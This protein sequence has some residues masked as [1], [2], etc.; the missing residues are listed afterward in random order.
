MTP[1]FWISLM[2]AYCLLLTIEQRQ[3]FM[4]LRILGTALLSLL[5]LGY[6]S[7]AHAYRSF[8]DRLMNFKFVYGKQWNDF[9][10]RSSSYSSTR[11]SGYSSYYGSSSRPSYSGISSYVTDGR[12]H[13]T[14]EGN[15]LAMEMNYKI[16]AFQ[17]KLFNNG[18]NGLYF[19]LRLG[20]YWTPLENYSYDATADGVVDSSDN[21]NP[22]IAV[23]LSYETY[24][25]DKMI[26]STGVQFGGAVGAGYFYNYGV[27]T[28]LSYNHVGLE[29]KIHRTAIDVMACASTYYSSGCGN[30]ENYDNYFGIGLIIQ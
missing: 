15:Y 7:Q 4:Q 16:Y 12:T 10:H 21:F 5:M 27:S 24:P 19:G 22:E 18:Y 14:G 3:Q 2:Q 20:G 11:S 28:A 8:Y 17:D 13:G 23:N 6:A 1:Y 30:S 26:W 29:F 9:D 25:N